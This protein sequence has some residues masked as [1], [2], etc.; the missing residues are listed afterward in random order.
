M[1]LGVQ[2]YCMLVVQSAAEHIVAPAPAAR[3]VGTVWNTGEFFSGHSGF[4]MFF[5][6]NAR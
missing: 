3:A 2:F 1:F 5:G 4:F 6:N